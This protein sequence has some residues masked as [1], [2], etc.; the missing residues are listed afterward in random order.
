MNPETLEEAK[1]MAKAIADTA[2]SSKAQVFSIDVNIANNSFGI[3][4]VCTCKC[5][6]LLIYLYI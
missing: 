6:D 5:V 2:G 3:Y 1:V 4:S